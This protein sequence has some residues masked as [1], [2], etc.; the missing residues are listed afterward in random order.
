M[1]SKNTMLPVVQYI[2]GVWTVWMDY[3]VVSKSIALY[4]PKT[5]K[6]NIGFSGFGL[7]VA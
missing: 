2:R 4:V 3:G 5:G 7:T 1:F 6:K